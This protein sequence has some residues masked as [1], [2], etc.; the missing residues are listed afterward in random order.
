LL[1]LPAFHPLAPS[2]RPPACLPACLQYSDGAPVLKNVSF[3][4][5]G[6]STVAL[7]GATGSGK[8]TILRLLF[9]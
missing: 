1:F 4:V 8:S 9:R 7:V 6:G 5:P 3:T 2:C